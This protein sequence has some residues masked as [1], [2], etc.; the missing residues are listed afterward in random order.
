M[1]PEINLI[2]WRL[3]LLE[4]CALK[5][6]MKTGKLVFSQKWEKHLFFNMLLL[7]K[8]VFK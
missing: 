2:K 7:G 5:F 8:A 6:L 1:F 3:I 4:T